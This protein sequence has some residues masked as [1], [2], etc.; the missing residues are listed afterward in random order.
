MTAGRH[1]SPDPAPGDEP[2]VGSLMRSPAVTVEAD[3]HV[4]SAAYLMKHSGAGA[5]VV[6]ADDLGVVPIAV[7]TDVEVSHAVADGQDPNE[8]RINQL[9]L[10]RPVAIHPG[11]SVTEAAEQMLGMSLQHLPVVDDG[12]LVGVVGVTEVCRAL[13]TRGRSV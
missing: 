9:R 2:T 1:A 4:A 3:A 6:T 13:L 12:R 11:T 8:T 10:P 5:L 7:L